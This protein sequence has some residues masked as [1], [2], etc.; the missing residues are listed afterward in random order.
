MAFTACQPP[1]L[2][3]ENNFPVSK[4]NITAMCN[5]IK[6]EISGYSCVDYFEKT[7]LIK[8]S[9]ETLKINLNKQRLKLIYQTKGKENGKL[10]K[11]YQQL[12]KELKA[13][14]KAEAH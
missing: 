8:D 7:F 14:S 4:E 1:I 3:R 5:T 9:L 6:Q 10:F 13:G 11:Q 2:Y 12:T